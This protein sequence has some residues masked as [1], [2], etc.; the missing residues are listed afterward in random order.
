MRHVRGLT[1][2][3]SFGVAAILGSGLACS[4]KGGSYIGRWECASGGGNFFEI[5]VN[6]EAFLVIDENG[7]TYPASVD[8]KGTLVVS[9]VPLMGSLP[10]PIDSNSNELICSACSCNR[11]TKKSN[12]AQA[13]VKQSSIDDKEAQKKTVADIRNVGT[14]MFSWLTDQ[15]GAGAAGQPQAW[16]AS[17]IVALK[18]Y[19]LISR[20]EL[21]KILVPK[22]IQSIQETDGW[23]HPYEFYLNTANPVAKEVMS[24][25][26]PGRDGRF[27]ATDYTVGPFA[28]NN[29]D[30]DIVWSDGF[31][32]RWPQAQ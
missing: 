14:A 12:T 6:K 32:V 25:R 17:K 27:S 1:L 9:G 19:P 2:L 7:H 20:N 15:V 8:D 13:E 24:I 18:Q 5:K 29:F 30:E 23:G 16:G 21:E 11:Y 28:S 22:Y 10:L 4:V 31:F 26:S 3:W